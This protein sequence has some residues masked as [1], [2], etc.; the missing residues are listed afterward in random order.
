MPFFC[1]PN[2]L[3]LSQSY[4]SKCDIHSITIPQVKNVDEQDIEAGSCDEYSP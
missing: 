2:S 1:P 3:F 4:L